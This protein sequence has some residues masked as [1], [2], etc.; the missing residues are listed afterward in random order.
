MSWHV[1]IR[2]AAKTDLRNAHQ[3]YEKQRAGLGDEFLLSAGRAFARLE[4]SP[5][6]VPLY[7][8]QFRRVMFDRFPYKV[9]FQIE[10][11]AVIVFRIIHVS[12]D[13]PSLL[14]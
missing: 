7:Y 8:R 6:R 4:D 2:R 5:D 14:D 9:F 13:H 10:G 3:W 12:R 11:D 1:S